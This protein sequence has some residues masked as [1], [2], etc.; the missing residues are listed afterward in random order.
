[1]IH[2]TTS[3]D[4]WSELHLRFS[5]QSL[6]HVMDLKMQLHSLQKGHLSMQSYLD[7]KCSIVDRLRLVGSPISDDDLQLYILHGIS[8]EY[9]SLIVS[10]NSKP[11]V[12]P[13]NELAGLLLA[14]KQ[15]LSK[16]TLFSA[17]SSSSL[18]IPASL[19]P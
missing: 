6:A 12:V 5:T 4:L 19:T 11:G 13:F 8:L 14:H 15:R 7:K 10:L 1:V 9:D 2:C 18:P 17:S 16:H 3:A